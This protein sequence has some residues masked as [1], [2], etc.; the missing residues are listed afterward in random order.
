MTKRAQKPPKKKKKPQPWLEAARARLRGGA[1][2][3]HEQEMSDAFLDLAAPF[4]EGVDDEAEVAEILHLVKIAWNLPLVHAAS[5]EPGNEGADARAEVAEWL[6]GPQ[7]D[8]EALV[9]LIKGRVRVYRH[10][11]AL[12]A[13]VMV[14]RVGSHATIGLRFHG[15]EVPRLS[16]LDVE[17]SGWPKI[18]HSLL[19]L[20]RPARDLLKV[21]YGDAEAEEAIGLAM[22]A[23]NLPV[24]EPSG[25]LVSATFRLGMLEAAARARQLAPAW[26]DAFEAMVIARETRFAYDPRIIVAAPTRIRDGMIEVQAAALRFDE[27]EPSRR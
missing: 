19:E 25:A 11:A 15:E 6:A 21:P 2:A 27:E 17:D 3:R 1:D 10:C 22:V 13:E 16:V 26:R 12:L 24:L 5:T 23:W 20:S 8:R 4:I 9:P 14:R 18:S 7:A